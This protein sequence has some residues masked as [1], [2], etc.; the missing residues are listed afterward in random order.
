MM[1]LARRNMLQRN[2]RKIDILTTIQKYRRLSVLKA[3]CYSQTRNVDGY[4]L[5]DELSSAGLLVKE[6]NDGEGA[7]YVVLLSEKG[8]DVLRKYREM[9]GLMEDC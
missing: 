8:S 7:G 5:V 2:L 1:A 6:A 4:R 3:V 9:L